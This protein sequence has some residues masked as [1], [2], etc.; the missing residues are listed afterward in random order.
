MR[1]ARKLRPFLALAGL[2]V[3]LLV[4]A[5]VRAGEQEYET[6][7][8]LAGVKL[9]LYKTQHGEPP[10]QPGCIPALHEKA[11]AEDIPKNPDLGISIDET[12]K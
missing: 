10:G 6:G 5:R 9:P 11:K 2:S 8:P 4:A 7:G 3:L 1:P 12:N